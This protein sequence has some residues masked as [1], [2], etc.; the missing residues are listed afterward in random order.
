MCICQTNISVLD[1]HG[2]VGRWWWWG[3]LWEDVMRVDPHAWDSCPYQR[4]P[5]EHPAPC[6]LWRP[7]ENT[8]LWFRKQPLQDTKS[9][10]PWP[11]SPIFRTTCKHCLL[12]VSHSVYRLLLEQYEWTNVSLFPFHCLP[13]IHSLCTHYGQIHIYM[14]YTNTHPET[15]HTDQQEQ[16]SRGQSSYF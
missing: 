2:D 3:P 7:S 14:P 11:G 5:R 4:D 6:T 12:F 10:M 15:R 1:R 8:L 16:V 13:N 9:S